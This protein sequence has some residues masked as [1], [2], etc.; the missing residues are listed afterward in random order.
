LTGATGGGGGAGLGGAIFNDGGSVT[1]R[2]STFTA[3]GANGGLGGFS[4][5]VESQSGAGAGG[6]IF[7]L[8]GS[9]TVNDSTIAGNSTSSIGD[10]PNTTSGGGI[11]VF[12]TATASFA[13]FNTIIF[14]NG[15]NECFW[16]PTSG[17]IAASGSHNL[18]G[19]PAPFFC[20]GVL[21]A[22]N[23][24]LGP[25]QNNGGA[26]PTM[27][28]PMTS[29]AFNAASPINAPSPVNSL[30]TDQRGQMRPA[31]GMG[32]IPDIGA[33]ELCL[34]GPAILQIPCPIIAASI[35]PSQT[36]LT[37]QVNP[38]AGG[39]TA[40]VPGTYTV[41]LGSVQTLEA[42]PSSGFAFVTWTGA[43]TDPNNPSTTIVMTGPQT[44][45]A[46]FVQAT[47]V[48]NLSG[49]GTAALFGRPERIDLT[50]TG[51]GG[52]T[53]YNVLRGTTPGGE[54][55]VPI[56]TTTTTAYTDTS[57]LM[58]GT[59]YYYVVQP[60]SGGAAVC[61]SNETAVKTP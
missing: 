9:L 56:G 6:A 54:G 40:P 51:F 29:P 2:N 32:G 42:T 38:A 31:P 7:S 24:E 14:G 57:G 37:V 44:V 22:I 17:I 12:A 34:Q 61:T 27:A 15:A 36:T 41:G 21:T 11:E 26:T 13:L 55:P 58:S 45:T 16:D 4:A 20:P 46:N 19:N 50:W 28:I 18:V 3:N 47:C 39:T 10:V 33:F 49:R 48:N 8:N 53:A 60:V 23:P 43:V 25:L 1:I 35:F 59:T 30:P 52:A 5:S